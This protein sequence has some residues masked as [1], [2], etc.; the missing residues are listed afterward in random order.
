M[1]GPALL[2]AIGR[3]S[4]VALVLNGVIGSSVFG[5][6][7]VIGGKLGA[8]SPL[9]WL[10]AALGIGTVVACFAEVASRFSEAGGPYLYAREAFGPF[11]GFQIG[12]LLWLARVTA[13]AALANLLVSYLG[14]F[15]PAAAGGPAGRRA[16]RSCARSWGS[17]R[18]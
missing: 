16:R 4:L 10:V 8:M 12:W 17:S 11:A 9:A 18:S 2:R 14:V 5:L 1:T 3:W 15:W 7:S 6:P 13:F